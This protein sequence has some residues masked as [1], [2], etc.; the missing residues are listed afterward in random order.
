MIEG[1]CEAELLRGD[2][3]MTLPVICGESGAMAIA[4]HSPQA[5]RRS[6]CSDGAV[7]SQGAVSAC[8]R[9][10]IRVPD[11]ADVTAL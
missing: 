4:L 11:D 9:G 7:C 5:C 6:M 2:A 8:G 1:R 10:D 3:G